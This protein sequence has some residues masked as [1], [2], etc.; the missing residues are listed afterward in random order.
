MFGDD[1]GCRL[2]TVSASP[3]VTSL[4]RNRFQAGDFFEV[5]F[6]KV[7]SLVRGSEMFFAQPPCGLALSRF[8][9]SW[10]AW[11]GRFVIIRLIIFSTVPLWQLSEKTGSD[12]NLE[13]HPRLMQLVVE[14]L[15]S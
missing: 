5:V 4:T 12:T 9:R 14:K 11:P 13:L 3:T 6:L 15:P 10:S 7:S 1:P 8:V 2:I